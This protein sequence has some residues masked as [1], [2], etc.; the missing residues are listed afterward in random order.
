MAQSQAPAPNTS[1]WD[2][3]FVPDPR[4]TFL[5]AKKR[6]ACIICKENELVFQTEMRACDDS[7]DSIPVLLPCGHVFGQACLENWLDN[8]NPAC[9]ACKI[10]LVYPVC[11]HN[12]QSR[13]LYEDTI[14]HVPKT[15]PEGGEINAS[16]EI[17]LEGTKHNVARQRWDSLVQVLAQAEYRLSCC[18][19]N[20]P[21]GTEACRRHVEDIRKLMDEVVEQTMGPR[22]RQW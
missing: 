10:A 6:M 2:D 17:C 12:I 1:S 22:P 19:P 5:Y 9:P 7:D 8:P 11:G 4:Y 3:C 18:D 13:P 15:I 21:L 20:N 16:C 14:F